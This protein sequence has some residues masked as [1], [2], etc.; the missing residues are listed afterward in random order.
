MSVYE[1]IP[2]GEKSVNLASQG[3]SP[4]WERGKRV[5]GYWIDI[6][7]YG[8]VGLPPRAG[9]GE[10]VDKHGYGWAFDPPVITEHEG[11]CE[12]NCRTLRQAK[13]A[14]EKAFDTWRQKK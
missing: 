11:K 14:V 13:R 6:I 9:D 8:W 1:Y 4:H 10:G 12:G 2:D 5:H 7:R 3:V